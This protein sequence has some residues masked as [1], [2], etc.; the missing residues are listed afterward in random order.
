[1]MSE[2][3]AL[4]DHVLGEY[5]GRKNEFARAAGITP[6]QL[7]HL[8]KGTFEPSME[9][10]LK[11]AR[12]SQTS[13][14]DLLRAAGKGFAADLIEQMYGKPAVRHYNVTARDQ[15]ILMLLRK[16]DRRVYRAVLLLLQAATR[17]DDDIIPPAA[18]RRGA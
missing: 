8:L 6:S 5:G 2:F 15:R 13:P 18:I 7:S 9:I 1:M 11:L 17:D 3:R 10:C 14:S 12:A 16:V 4:L